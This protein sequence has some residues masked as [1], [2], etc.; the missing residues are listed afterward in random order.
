MVHLVG[1]DFVDVFVELLGKT[2]SGGEEYEIVAYCLLF[3]C[4]VFGD[5]RRDLIYIHIGL[6]AGVGGG[7]LNIFE[8]L[9]AGDEV[10]LGVFVNCFFYQFFDYSVGNE[11][12][13]KK[14]QEYFV[15]WFVIVKG[16]VA[17]GYHGECR[18]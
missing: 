6:Y 17:F 2:G 15:C 7:V 4:V 9:S 3:S 16:Y 18:D 11:F 10:G 8:L 13:A 1:D 14:I 5:F 12:A